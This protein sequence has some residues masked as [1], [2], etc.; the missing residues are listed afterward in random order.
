[1]EFI[2]DGFSLGDEKSIKI[3]L[4]Q[5]FG[6]VFKYVKQ[7]SEKHGKTKVKDCVIVMPNYW[8]LDQR[9]IIL[10]AL[11]IAD[12]YPLSVISENTAAALQYAMNRQDNTTHRVL[13]YNLGANAL[14]VTLAE[15]RVA[16]DTKSKS[17]VETVHIIDEFGLARVG[18]LD[19]DVLLAQ[20]FTKIFENKYKKQLNNR[21][22]V[23]ML[24]ECEQVKEVLS[25]NK[26]GPLV[27]EELFDGIDF[28]SKITR[29]EFEEVIKD[30]LEKITQPI[31]PFLRA[32]DIRPK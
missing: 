27:I 26:D 14:Q 3:S 13:F 23:K 30:I 17:P 10:N 7:L 24:E 4:E 2:L 18:G 32:N 12:L 20:H 5:V 11:A 21:A 15:F 29:A 31:V 8:T 6:M 22:K 25:A 28:Q 16:N 1:V 19:I 9:V